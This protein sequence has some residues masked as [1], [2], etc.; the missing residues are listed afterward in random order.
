[1]KK[2]I[3]ISAIAI[4]TF[5]WI[6]PTV[7]YSQ[8]QGGGP[9]P[10][11]PAHGYRA[12]TKHIYFPDQNMYFDLQKGMYIYLSNGNWVFS[13]KLPT[14]SGNQNLNTAMKVELDLNDPDP[15]KY[16]AEHLVKYKNRKKPFN[17]RENGK[18]PGKDHKKGNK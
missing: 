3:I 8:K 7:A 12:K 9:P 16:N 10:W 18:R 11:A 6:F 4:I 2:R 13:A 5:L 15:Y 17:R 14:L 1:M